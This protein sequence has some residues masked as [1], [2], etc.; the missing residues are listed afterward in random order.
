MLDRER[1]KAARDGLR[2]AMDEF[3]DAAS[4]NDDL[5]ESVGNPHGRGRL[6]DRVGW[7]EANWSSNRDD[8]RERLDAVHERIDGI[9]TGWDDWETEATAALEDAG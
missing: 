1:L 7:F 4:T 6:R 3:E 2:A 8:L 9:V 5:E